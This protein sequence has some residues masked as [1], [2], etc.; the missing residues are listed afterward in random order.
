MTNCPLRQQRQT[1]NPS[2]RH[3]GSR[4]SLLYPCDRRA[5]ALGYLIRPSSRLIGTLQAGEDTSKRTS[6]QRP[7]CRQRRRRWRL[8]VSW[9]P[10]NCAW[11][12]LK[13]PPASLRRSRLRLSIAERRPNTFSCQWHTSWRTPSQAPDAVDNV[14]G[15]HWHPA[16]RQSS[17]PHLHPSSSQASLTWHVWNSIFMTMRQARNRP[18]LAG[19]RRWRLAIISKSRYHYFSLFFFE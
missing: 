2:Q 13:Q 6:T 18:L 11:R 4:S 19:R 15:R 1:S 7:R 16:H 5:P 17:P 3:G 14:H 8:R 12:W 10:C 9:R